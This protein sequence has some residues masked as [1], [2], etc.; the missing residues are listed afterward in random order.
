MQPDYKRLFFGME[1]EAPWPDL[2]PFGRHLEESHRHLT[3]AFLGNA[4]FSKLK[5][6]LLTFPPPPFKVGFGGQF[7]QCLF[8]PPKHPKCVA[9]HVDWLEESLSIELF[10]QTLNEWLDAN[11]FPS[12]RK[13]PFN[14]HVTLARLPFNKKAW[15]KAFSPLPVMLK[16]LHLYESLGSSKYL[17]LWS[18]PLLA[19]FE[20]IEHTADIAYWIRGESY[21]QLFQH[22]QLALA[23]FFPSFLPFFS[24]GQTFTSIEAVIFALN[25]VVCHADREIGCPFKAISYHTE[26]AIKENVI[27]W[28]M[29]VDV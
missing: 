5:E 17:P 6:A 28:E 9:W 19:P 20:E 10:H 8:L 25:E 1:A 14:P 27:H 23:F 24:K 16:T 4:D 18:Y 29:I 12:D 13:H 11:G 22:A 15:Q 3:L 21:N 2:F 7:D 26:M